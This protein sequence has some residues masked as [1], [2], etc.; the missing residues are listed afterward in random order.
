MCIRD[1]FKPK[2]KL[3]SQ[4]GDSEETSRD[5]SE[6]NDED[7]EEVLVF[8]APLPEGKRIKKS[9]LLEDSD[10]EDFGKPTGTLGP[11]LTATKMLLED[12]D[13]E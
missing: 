4:S 9:T 7:D 13:E 3:L 10:D 12:S 1:R 8:A 11:S 6:N 2:R 5:N